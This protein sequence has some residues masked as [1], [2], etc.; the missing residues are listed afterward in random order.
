MLSVSERQLLSK[1]LEKVPDRLLVAS[2]AERQQYYGICLRSRFVQYPKDEL[3]QPGCYR[4]VKDTTCVAQ[5]KIMDPK[6]EMQLHGDAFF[7]AWT[8][9]P[10]T[11]PSNTALCVGPEIEYLA[12]QTFNPYNGIPITVVLGKPLLHTLFNPKGE[13]EEIPASYDPAQKLLPYKVIASWKGKELE[14]MR[15]EQQIGRAHV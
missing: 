11:L 9:T 3:N 8:T 5:F 2:K 4:D 14:G 7:L 6:P 15:Y 1:R 10:W 12:V 13:C